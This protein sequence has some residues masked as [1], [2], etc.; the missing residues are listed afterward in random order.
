MKVGKKSKNF[1]RKL[2][3]YLSVD[4]PGYTGKI[5]EIQ[6]DGGEGNE[7]AKARD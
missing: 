7:H 5:G 2:K 6:Q 4:M 3:S 1:K